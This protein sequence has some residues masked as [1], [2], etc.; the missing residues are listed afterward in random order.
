MANKITNTQ[1][2]QDIADAIRAKNG[3]A[4]T[5]TPAQMAQAIEDLPS[6]GM[7]ANLEA[8]MSGTA[9]GEVSVT[10]PTYTY[11]MTLAFGDNASYI[12]R[13]NY[14]VTGLT[15]E[16]VEIWGNGNAGTAGNGGFFSAGNARNLQY[17]RLPDCVDLNLVKSNTYANAFQNLEE[18]T[19]PKLT[20]IHGSNRTFGGYNPT[21][22]RQFV[23]PLYTS[24]IFDSM[25]YYCNELTLVDVKTSQIAIS[26]FNS[27]SVLDALVLRGATVASLMNVNA[28]TGTPIEAGTGYIYVPRSLISSYEAATN[29]ST[30]AGQFRAIEDYT[31]DGTLTGN[32]VM[33][34]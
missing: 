2:Y 11:A 27:C 34:T 25:F 7:D 23:C 8:L 5:Y 31:D 3:L 12:K 1:H 30:Y 29:W 22:L 24:M 21:K 32:F 15:I 33:P 6:G 9:S 13:N 17:I 19:A 28:F 20:A 10:L 16:G 4:T 14:D 26:A 18:F